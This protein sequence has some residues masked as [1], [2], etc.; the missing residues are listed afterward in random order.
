[1]QRGGGGAEEEA[2][3]RGR[4][5]AVERDL[6]GRRRLPE[7][8]GAPLQGGGVGPREVEEKGSLVPEDGQEYRTP[9]RDS[10]GQFLLSILPRA[11]TI[12]IV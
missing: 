12:E 3:P 10:R 6:W 7:K 11:T 5:P 1:M 8:V 2:A 4:R 9:L